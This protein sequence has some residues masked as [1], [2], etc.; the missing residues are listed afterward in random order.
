MQR[1]FQ[2]DVRYA[3]ALDSHFKDLDFLDDNDAKDTMKMT[4]EVIQINGEVS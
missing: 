2:R 1:H 3:S 4:A